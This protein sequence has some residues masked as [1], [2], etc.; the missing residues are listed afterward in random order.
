MKLLLVQHVLH[1]VVLTFNIFH[2]LDQRRQRILK[3]LKKDNVLP[4]AI[5]VLS[6]KEIESIRN[7][8]K[9]T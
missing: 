9:R 4:A 1:P 3:T 8:S 6:L 5:V 7:Q 2:I